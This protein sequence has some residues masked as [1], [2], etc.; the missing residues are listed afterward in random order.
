LGI[1]VKKDNTLLQLETHLLLGIFIRFRFS[2]GFRISIDPSSEPHVR[3]SIMNI[4]VA[5]HT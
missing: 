4:T 1:Q 5:H 3:P 2:L